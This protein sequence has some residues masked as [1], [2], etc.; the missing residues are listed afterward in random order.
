MQTIPTLC[1]LECPS[2]SGIS[3]HDDCGISLSNLHSGLH[4]MHEQVSPNHTQ[5]VDEIILRLHP[6]KV[7]LGITIRKEA[8]V[9]PCYGQKEVPK[10]K[11]LHD[12]S[13]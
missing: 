7:L 5:E 13:L 2:L 9:Y 1:L 8:F 6:A 10:N 3:L 12:H 11:F 4:S